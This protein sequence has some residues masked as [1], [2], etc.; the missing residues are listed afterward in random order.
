MIYKFRIWANKPYVTEIFIN[1]DSD[2]QAAETL[3]GI[4]SN[5]LSWTECPMSNLKMTYEIVKDVDIK[6]RSDKTSEQEF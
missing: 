6:S 4:K 1:A 2:T 5:S 3:N